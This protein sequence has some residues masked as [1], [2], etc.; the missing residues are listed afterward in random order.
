MNIK[1]SVCIP[2][3]NRKG[4]LKRAIESVLKQTYNNYELIIS[5][6]CSIDGTEEMIK[7]D[8]LDVPNMVYY[9]NKVNRGMVPNWRNCIEKATGDFYII[10][11]DDN[12]LIYD[13]YLLDASLIITQNSNIQLVFGDFLIRFKEKDQMESYR[14]NSYVKGQDVYNN[15]FNF[16]EVSQIFFVLL[17]RETAIKNDFYIDNLITHDVQSF[18]IS[19]LQGDVGYIKRLIGI[20]DMTGDDNV[21]LSIQSKWKDYINYHD[22]ILAFGNKNGLKKSFYVKPLKRQLRQSYNSQLTRL[23]KEEKDW[24]NNRIRKLYGQKYFVYLKCVDILYSI[25]KL[26]L[27]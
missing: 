24:Y 11:D 15:Y 3:Y 6:N 26:I 16:K 20:Y 9:K 1:I 14:F 10:L 19:M 27:K 17:N 25:G 21:V 22:R 23:N 18:L 5:D 12:Y 8:F 2:T 4:K 7:T 13:D